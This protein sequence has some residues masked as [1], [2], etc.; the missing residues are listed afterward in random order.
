MDPKS[1]SSGERVFGPPN[2][3]FDADWIAAALRSVRPELDHPTS[4]HLIEQAWELLRGQDLRG[5]RLTAALD[6]D[7][8]MDAELAASVSAVAS[9][10]AELF[11]DRR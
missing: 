1:Y 7:G 6:A 2:G 5:E 3:T 10:A 4:V 9:E 8:A 11:L